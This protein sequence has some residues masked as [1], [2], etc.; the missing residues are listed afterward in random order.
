[1]KKTWAFQVE[2]GERLRKERQVH[3]VSIND[4]ADLSGVS[5]STILNIENARHWPSLEKL[6][7]IAK[8]LKCSVGDLVGP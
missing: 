4:L 6:W 8:A 2:V 7:L 5:R 1:M 3:D